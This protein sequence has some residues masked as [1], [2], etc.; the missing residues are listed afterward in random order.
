ML[1]DEKQALFLIFSPSAE[2]G[3]VK[4]AAALLFRRRTDRNPSADPLA[5]GDVAEKMR[6]S[7]RCSSDSPGELR[8]QLIGRFSPGAVS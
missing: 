2:A 4:Q 5:I 6:S 1:K 8:Q 7:I 3:G